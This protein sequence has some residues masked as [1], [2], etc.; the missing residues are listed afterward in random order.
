MIY[1]RIGIF[2][3]MALLIVSIVMVPLVYG[4]DWSP[5]MRLTWD[6]G[7]DTMPS[8]MKSNDGSLWVFW[9]SRRTGRE[10]LYYKTYNSSQVHPWSA[11]VRLTDNVAVDATPFAAQTTDN[12]TWVVW[13]TNRTGNY[14]IFYKI[15]DGS[16]WS[17]DKR[18]TEDTRRDELPSIVQ[19]YGK[20]WVFWDSKRGTD[21]FDL[22]YKTTSDGENWSSDTLL[23]ISSATLDDWGPR[24]M[25]AN[26]GKIWLVWVRSDDIYYS[27]YD[28]ASWSP[29]DTV[30][31]GG[32]EDWHPS[33]MQANDNKIWVA[34]D[35]GRTDPP[36]QTDIFYSIYDGASWSTAVRLTTDSYEDVAPSILQDKGGITWIV[37]ASDRSGFNDIFYKTSSVPEAHDVEVFSVIPSKTVVFPDDSVSIEVVARN[38]GSYDET[39][40]ETKCYVDNNLIG[41]KSVDLPV[42]DLLPLY[43]TWSTSGYA[44][45]DHVVSAN[46]SYVS[47]ETHVADNTYVDGVVRITKL[48]KASFTFSPYYPEPN[49]LVTFDASSSTPNGG[50]IISYRWDFGDE[51]ITSVTEPII[52]HV[53]TTDGS[54][55]VFLTITDSE[56]LTDSTW[57]AVP[58]YVHDVA[59][60]GGSCIDK[61]PWGLWVS[62]YVDVVNQGTSPESF[63]LYALLNDTSV[64][65]TEVW[66][67]AGETQYGVEILCDT[68]LVPPGLYKVKARVDGVLGERDFADN[69]MDLGYVWLY[70]LDLTVVDVAPYV[71]KAYVGNVVSVNATVEN[72]GTVDAHARLEFYYDSTLVEQRNVFV[73]SGEQQNSTFLWYTSSLVPGSYTLKA[74][75]TATEEGFVE[76]DTADNTFTDGSVKIKIP[77]DVDGDG[78]VDSVDLNMLMTAYGSSLGSSNW[79]VDCDINADKLVSVLD[80]NALAKY[81]GKTSP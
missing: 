9:Q 14:D 72:Q 81:F 74:S 49:E 45:G 23:S 48:P 63:Y 39:L 41:T 28:G 24:V 31:K 12:K 50:T 65:L 25:R 15:Y 29:P 57:R 19:A 47:G 18:L 33:V 13:M 4:V 44:L 22:Y 7:E 34:W 53:Y 70:V 68:L 38:H 73:G 56:G 46:V 17:V 21:N 40:V 54:Y 55:N 16:L 52:T 1:R 58:V 42:G 79:D 8:V 64:G 51:N 69:I 77:G 32:Y 2:S 20:I 26:D 75:V 80:L 67:S 71:T 35:V 43:F 60:V 62:C 61:Y 3:F 78:D 59:V 5:D 27:V 10:E 37:W 36:V 11:E 76:L 6:S 66:L 30:S